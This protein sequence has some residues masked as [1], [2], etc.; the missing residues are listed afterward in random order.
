MPMD[1]S[2]DLMDGQLARLRRYGEILSDFGRLVGEGGDPEGLAQLACVQAARAIGIRH[3][4]AMR[5]R[6]EAGDLL[7]VAGVGWR[8]GVVGEVSLGTDMASPAGQ[9]LRTRLPVVIDD[10]P[11]STEFR[12]SVVLREHGIV[13]ALNVPIAVDGYVWGV[14]EVDSDVPRHFG[15][16]DVRFLS[17]L[18]SMLGL[19]LRGRVGEA[20]V[21]DAA[22]DA[23]RQLAQERMLRVE[24]QHRSKNDLQLILSLLVMQRRRLEDSEGKRIFGHVLDRVAAI[25]VA[26]DQL[27]LGRGTGQ[28]EMVDY[29]TAL[30]GNL[31]KRREGVQIETHLARLELPHGRAVPLGLIVNELVTNA[32]KHAF[33]DG[34]AGVIRVEF[35]VSPDG[36]GRLCVRDDGAGMG[37][38]RPGSA[39]TELVRRLVQQIGGRLV[40]LAQERGAGFCVS[41]PVAA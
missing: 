27:D 16:D 2:R 30:C 5:H 36:E 17:A 25:G 20:G 23:A 39:G 4:K 40:Q 41:F 35:E 34:R 10:L 13:S 7:I 9:S 8:P 37:P 28:I 12:F 22:A 32:L 38:P 18:G 6:P 1:D 31:S 14:L 33:P 21:L 11:G 24:L 15:P 26:H 19:A 29:L 3:A